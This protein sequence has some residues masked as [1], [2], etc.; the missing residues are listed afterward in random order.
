MARQARLIN[1]RVLDAKGGGQDSYVIGAIQRAIALKSTYN[2]R[3]INLSLGRPVYESYTTDPLCQAVEAAW[4]AGIVVVVAAGNDGRDNSGGRT[5]YG[6]VNSP[7]NDP[8]LITVGAMKT[9][10]TA[11][12]GDDEI[13]SYS[14]KGPTYLDHVMK[15]DLVAPGNQI[16]S[17]LM[18]TNNWISELYPQNVVP[19]SYFEVNGNSTL[20][21]C[22]VWLSGTSMAAPVVSGAAAL[23]IQKDST[24][25]PD[26]VKARL[27]KTATKNFPTYSSAT[28]P[29]TSQTYTSQY[30]PSWCQA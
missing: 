22:Y 5:G 28:D 14:S 3:V 30:Q 2:I 9:R 26:M 19:Y 24:L 7:G 10:K 6:T 16:I 21:Y 17:L 20:S 12:R 29:T 1:L 8:Y 27:M 23:M 25:T 13:A 15:P 4:K 18:N 11:A